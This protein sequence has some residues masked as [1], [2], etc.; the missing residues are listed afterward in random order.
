MEKRRFREKVE[1][2][3]NAGPNALLLMVLNVQK[4]FHTM[5]AKTLPTVRVQ[6]ETSATKMGPK[7]SVSGK[8]AEW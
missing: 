5:N 1:V 3:P 4:T 2:L 6:W 8:L 7:T